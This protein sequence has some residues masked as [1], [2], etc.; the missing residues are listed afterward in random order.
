MLQCIEYL[1][2]L[3]SCLPFLDWES[4]ATIVHALVTSKTG[5]LQCALCGPSVALDPEAAVSA[6]YCSTI[7]DQSEHFSAYN[8]GAQRSAQVAHLLLGNV[9]D[10]SIQHP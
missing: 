8:P 3:K 2:Q 7:A 5:I 4:L 10:V 1:S 9:Q 6:E